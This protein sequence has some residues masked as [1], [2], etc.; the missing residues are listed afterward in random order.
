MSGGRNSALRVVVDELELLAERKA[1]IAEQ[2][3]DVK[4]A[5]AAKGYSVKVIATILKLRKMSP[6]ERA[7]YQGLVDLYQA[8]LGMLDGT[9]LGKHARDR[10]HKKPDDDESPVDR[11]ETAGDATDGDGDAPGADDIEAARAQG[12]DAA[13]AGGDILDNPFTALDP[14]RAAWDEGFCMAAGSDGMD[15]PEAWRPKSARKPKPAPSDD[16]GSEDGGGDG[17]GGDGGEASASAPEPEEPAKPRRGRPP[18]KKP[19]PKGGA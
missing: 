14:R 11:D 3:K 5:A 16:A 12:G 9:P 4:A 6:E 2:E 15:L 1:A 7:D 18:K 13:L 8:E 10:L 17:D 19:D